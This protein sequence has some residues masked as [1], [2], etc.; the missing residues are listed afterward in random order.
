MKKLL[1]LA[2][3]AVLGAFA[4]IGRIEA[5]TSPISPVHPPGLEDCPRAC[6][7]NITSVG[8]PT[9]NAWCVEMYELDLAPEFVSPR[10]PPRS[11]PAPPIPPPL[12]APP[13]CDRPGWHRMADWMGLHPLWTDGAA[14]CVVGQ[15]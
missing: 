3:L 6:I 2:I 1:L 7:E 9:C 4:A 10:I 14:Y 8:Y 15:P 12:L 5:L 13:T 11:R